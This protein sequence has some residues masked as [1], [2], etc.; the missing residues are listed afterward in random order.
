MQVDSSPLVEH[1]EWDKEQEEVPSFQEL[2]RV[3]LVVHHIVVVDMLDI[4]VEGVLLALVAPSLGFEEDS[5]LSEVDP[6]DHQVP[7]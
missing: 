6:W 2:D 1:L 4:E 7:S 5:I 3:P